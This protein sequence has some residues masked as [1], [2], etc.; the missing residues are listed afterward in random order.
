MLSLYSKGIINGR[1]LQE[2]GI[3]SNHVRQGVPLKSIPYEWDNPPIGTHSF[4]LVLQDYDNVPDEGFSWIH[5]LVADIPLEARNLPVNASRLDNALIQGTN[6]WIIPYG[7]YAGV[8]SDLITHYGGPAPEREHEYE[9][10]IYALDTFLGLQNGFFYNQLL[11]KMD[12]HIIE[13]SVI[14]GVYGGDK[15]FCFD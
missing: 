9:T 6:S 15:V 3:Y 14:R 13:E 11:R 7:P 8:Q 1:I 2:Y 4:A 12:G 10:K 5:W